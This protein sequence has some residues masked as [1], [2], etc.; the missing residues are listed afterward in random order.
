MQHIEE[1]ITKSFSGEI[2]RAEK[3]LLIKWLNKDSENEIYFAQLKNIWQS[4]QAT[5][6][7]NEIDVNAAERSVM[8]KIGFNN[9]K[10]LS[11]YGW[12]QKIAAVI[13]L[14]LMLFTA[15]YIFRD[16]S[17]VDSNLVMQEV[18]SPAGARS[19][20]ELPDGSSVWLNA[21]SKLK[22][23][24]KFIKGERNVFL[25]GEAYFK[26]KSDNENPFQVKTKELTVTATGTEFNVEAFEQDT[27]MAVTLATG[28]VDISIE[29]K[30]HIMLSPDERICYNEKSNKYFVEE[31]DS[32][33]W[34]A[35]KDD[36]L[37]FREDRLDYV[38]KRLGLAYNT[39]IVVDDM[40]IASQP[41][42]AT[43]QGESLDEILRLIQLTAPI[44]Y[45]KTK[46]TANNDGS[47][48]KEKIIIVKAE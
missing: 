20:I 41:Y 10:R 5:F 43:F 42:R 14:P 46:R 8:Q 25:S 12:W 39:N 9:I 37:M 18:F 22:Y 24:V 34:S 29:N 6:S 32:Y 23:P 16:K 36:I 44:S 15:Y 47:Y 2:T 17:T 1:I 28:K 31:V 40:E 45:K 11:F 7:P 4:A 38:F 27:F 33:K 35:W 21:R 19:H 26:V 13:I 48:S 3:D 30:R